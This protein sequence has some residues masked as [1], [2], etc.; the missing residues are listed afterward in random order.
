MPRH[1][2]EMLLLKSNN[3]YMSEKVRVELVQLVA[4]VQNSYK[5]DSCRIID[6]Y[7]HVVIIYR[8]SLA[9]LSC[10]IR[11]SQHDGLNSYLATNP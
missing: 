7:I 9:S 1:N 4:A 3:T 8:R 2:L 5:T 10:Q 6:A 11:S